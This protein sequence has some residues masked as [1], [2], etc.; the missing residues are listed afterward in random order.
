VAQPTAS[1]VPAATLVV[2]AILDVGRDAGGGSSQRY[3]AIRLAAELV[4]RRGGVLLPTGERRQLELVVYDDGGQPARAEPAVRRLVADGAL[5][6]VGPSATES[7]VVVRSAAEA[8]GIPLIALHPDHDSDSESWRWTFS[9]A[10][11]SED[12]LAATIDFFVASGVDRFG[13]LAPSTMEASSL[14]RSLFRLAAAANIQVV[15]E[16]Q[17]PP[18]DDMHARRLALLQA[19][20]PRV[21][22][23]WPRDPSEAASIAREAARVPGLVPVFLGPAAAS[24]STLTLAGDAASVVRTVTLR[25]PVSDDLWDHDA[26]TPIIRDFRREL[27]A[28][29]GSP[30]TVEAAGAWDALRLIVAVLEQTR[31]SQMPPTRTAVRD[32]LE[33]TT[34]YLGASGAILFGPRRHDGLDRRALV[35]ARSE[36]RRWRLPP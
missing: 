5:A 17:Y 31:H 13:W 32:G 35:V 6:I 27:Q 18:G 3:D 23:A 9:L 11:R 30:A 20:D 25:L 1:P 21:I 24:P 22:L 10:P 34:D 19:S 33:A 7:A 28:R 14:R 36:G 12:A 16:A 4:N 26:L 2:G 15:G 29:T 8:A